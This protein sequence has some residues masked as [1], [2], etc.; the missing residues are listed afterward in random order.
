VFD[1]Q[2]FSYATGPDST[3]GLMSLWRVLDDAESM[4]SPSPGPIT[5]FVSAIRG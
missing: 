3:H 1:A 2:A 5:A 4:A